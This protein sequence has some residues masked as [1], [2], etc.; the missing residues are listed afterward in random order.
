MDDYDIVFIAETHTSGKLLKIVDGFHIISDPLFSFKSHGGMASYINLRLFPYITNI[1]FTKCTLS[2]SL[3][4]LPGFCFMLVYMYPL[5]SPNF[6]LNDFGILSEE[7]S[8]WINKGFV[9]YMGGDYNSRFGDFNI[10]S[11]RTL[12]W[13]YTQN[14][15]QTVN[16][17]GKKLA[18]ICEL[19]NILPLNHCCYYDW[20]WDGK[21]TFH[22]AGKSSQIDFILTNRQGRRY[23]TD[24]KIIDTSWH[25]SDHLPLSLKLHLPYQVSTDILLVRAIELNNSF[26]PVSKVPSHRFKFN[27]EPACEML[28]QKYPLILQSC[29]S[30]SPDVII[31]TFE[32]NLIPILKANRIKKE[33]IKPSTIYNDSCLECDELFNKYIES[34]QNQL[35]NK[36]EIEADYENYQTARNK[37]NSKVFKSHEDKYKVILENGD[38][39]KLWSEINWS[40]QHKG[41]GKQQIPIQVMSNYFEQLY[42][43][44]DINE[45]YEMQNLH[46]NTYIPITDDPITGNEL[47]TAFRKMKKGGYDFSL[48]VLNMLMSGFSQILLILFNLVFYVAYPINFGISLLSTIPKKGNLKLLTNYRGI[49]MQNILSLLYD[50][51]LTNRLIAW[52]KIHPEQSAFQKGKSTLNH[53]FLI[54]VTIGLTK[55]AKIPLFIGFFDLEKAFDKVSRPLLLKSLTKLGIG[56][57]IFYAIK[58]MYSTTKCIIKA[59]HKLSDIFLTHSGI[60]QGAPS[61]VILFIIFMDDFID[62]IRDNCIREPVIGLLHIL[63]HADDTAVMSTNKNLFIRKCNILLAAFKEKKVSLNLKKSGF[64][65]INPDICED[66]LDIKL[67]SGWLNYRSTFVYLGAIFSDNGAVYNDLNLHVSNR[68]KSVYVKLANF[69]RNNPAAPIIVKKKILNSCLNASLVY[70]CE[71]WGGASLQKAETLYRKAIKITFSMSNNT[72]NEIVFIETGLTELKSQIYKRQFVFWGKVLKNIEED[73]DSEISKVLKMAIDKNIQYLRHYQKLHRDYANKQECYKHYKN[74]FE[75]KMKQD[76]I[77]KTSVPSYSIL[78]DYVLINDNLQSP[79]FYH[80]YILTEVDRHIVTRYRCGSHFLKINTGRYNRSPIEKRLCKCKQVQT[81]QHV[82]F[83]CILTEPMRHGNFPSNFNDFFTNSVFAA[84]KLCQMERIL[85]IRKFYV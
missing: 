73:P 33:I 69:M 19:Q 54:R 23:V 59:G 46:T 53:I 18:G 51:I 4:I 57:A 7:I 25:L 70:G 26:Q 61:S 42:Q 64:L 60:K 10:I 50:R 63:L 85:K 48:P 31:R 14:I 37:M 66:R 24:F 43:P 21:Y 40:G 39:Q 27:F 35:S 22:K 3:S 74:C 15:D 65:V 6:D 30:N 1:R 36:E 12:K 8:F 84:T 62:I 45:K 29:N 75:I 17:H 82:L 20:T 41:S 76:I 72:P 52:A 28:N 2:F 67:D 32:E 58:A 47:Y 68:E 44:L 56:S 11:Q 55:Q 38:D 78:D 83:E 71:T 9:P 81:L 77:N 5:D 13:R 49:H 80:E 34:T 79:K 16:S